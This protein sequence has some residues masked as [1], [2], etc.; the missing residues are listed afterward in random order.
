MLLKSIFVAAA[1]K[2]LNLSS[3]L[4]M[5]YCL[6]SLR[7]IIQPKI[8]MIRFHLF[9]DS[10]ILKMKLGFWAKLQILVLMSCQLG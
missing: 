10:L 2:L 8:F 5:E 4:E 3:L 6:A 7:F 1:E 9:W